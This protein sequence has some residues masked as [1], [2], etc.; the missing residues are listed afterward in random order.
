M[1]GYIYI[2][3]YNLKVILSVALATPDVMIGF[4]GPGVKFSAQPLHYIKES[5]GLESRNL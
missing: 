1:N 2:H 4:L 3:S 5:T